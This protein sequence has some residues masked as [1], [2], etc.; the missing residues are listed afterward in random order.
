MLNG[1][2]T[3][4]CVRTPEFGHLRLVLF[5]FQNLTGLPDGAD[6]RKRKSCEVTDHRYYNTAGKKAK[7]STEARVANCL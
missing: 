5:F 1:C 6:V 7:G 3:S 4:G 2:C